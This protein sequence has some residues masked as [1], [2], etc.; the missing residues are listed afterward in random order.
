[1][2]TKLQASL[3]TSIAR[4]EFTAVNSAE[5]ET[6]DDIGWVWANCVIETAE[7]KGVF[8]SLVNAGFARHSGNKG[9]DACVT[10]TQAGFD[11]YKA[12]SMTQGA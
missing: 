2:T 6:L 10:L 4:S 11:A 3:L 12:I 7:D 1:M 8:T 9:R 5:P